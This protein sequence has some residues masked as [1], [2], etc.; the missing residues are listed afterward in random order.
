MFWTAI[1]LWTGVAKHL[2]RLRHNNTDDLWKKAESE[3]LVFS[4]K[5]MHG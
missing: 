5:S 1:G 4:V 2:A 3:T